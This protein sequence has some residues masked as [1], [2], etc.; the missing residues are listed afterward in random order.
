VKIELSQERENFNKKRKVQIFYIAIF[1]LLIICIPFFGTKFPPATDL[2][3]HLAQIRLFIEHNSIN[4]DVYSIQWFGPNNLIYF[5]IGLGWAI[6]G[7]KYLGVMILLFLAFTWLMSVFFIGYQLQ[8]PIEGLILALPLFFNH[9]FYWGFLNFIIGFPVFL[10]WLYLTQKRNFEFFSLY[11]LGCIGLTFLLYEGHALWLLMGG[12][13][14]ILLSL[15]HKF[16]IKQFLFWV[17][18]F[19]PVGLLSLFWYPRFSL[20]RAQAGFDVFP[21]WYSSLFE[22]LSFKWVVNSAFGGIRG[23]FEY[24]FFLIIV[25]WIVFAFIQ[26]RKGLKTKINVNLMAASIL[27]LIFSFFA[28]DKYMNTIYFNTRW[29]PLGVILLLLAMPPLKFPF[30]IKVV[31]AL[32]VL[33]I[34]SFLTARIWHIYEKEELSGLEASLVKITPYSRVLG[35]D[36]V[37]ESKFIKN[38]PFLQIFAYAQVF[39]G[40]K[41]N[42]SFA[43]HYSGIVVFRKKRK[44]S[45][46][47]GLEWFPERVRKSDLKWFDYV[48]INAKNEIHAVFS[49]LNELEALSQHGPW[50]IYKVN[51]NNMKN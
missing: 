31:T 13:W 50:R 14:I 45:W 33:I 23:P 49:N 24:I 6:C 46:T 10:V 51:T 8:R 20:Q 7:P 38:R 1:C 47:P 43:E 48:L 16:S 32:I 44:I 19:I 25:I 26:N 35:L 27:L 9:A 22:R 34:F 21:H 15:I 39:K 2:P 40:A 28:P 12:I 11:Q 18:N 5:F 42:F 4:P 30:K 17:S 41:I 37:K 3:Q 29:F 36:F